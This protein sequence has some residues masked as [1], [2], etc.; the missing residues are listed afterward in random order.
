MENYGLSTDW[1]GCTVCLSVMASLRCYLSWLVFSGI[2]YRGCWYLNTRT[3]LG[4]LEGR[5]RDLS[6][7]P[8]SRTNPVS[9]CGL[10][11]Q[12]GSFFL[13]GVSLGYC[14]SG[15][16]RLADYQYVQSSLCR[17]GRGGYSRGYFIMDVFEI[18]NQRSF[19]DSVAGIP[20]G[21]EGGGASAGAVSS[22]VLILVATILGLVTIL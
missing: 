13:F 12:N 20:E 2:Q 17:D 9:K 10:A 8:F 21:G 11:A 15:S 19:M 16:N 1:S 14:I 4:T 22:T 5:N 6:D 18:S 3:R 7:N